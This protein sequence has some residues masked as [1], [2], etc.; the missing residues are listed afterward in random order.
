MPAMGAP[1]R[2]VSAIWSTA[3][4]VRASSSNIS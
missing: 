2:E 1:C 3:A 4:P